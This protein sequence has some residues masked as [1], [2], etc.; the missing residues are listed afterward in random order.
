MVILYVPNEGHEMTVEQAVL[1]KPLVKRYE[2]VLI[3][4]ISQI[5]LSLNDMEN[6]HSDLACPSDE[7]DFWVYKCKVVLILSK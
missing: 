5:R 2:N 4:W 7:Y 3:Y 6:V 1:D